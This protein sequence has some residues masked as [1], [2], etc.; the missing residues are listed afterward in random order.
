MI[1]R[2]RLYKVPNCSVYVRVLAIHHQTNEKIVAKL[3]FEYKSGLEV[4]TKN[5]VL[6]PSKIEH[7]VQ[8]Q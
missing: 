7:W 2:G 1:K 4:E 3:R 6:E 5:Y 8:V